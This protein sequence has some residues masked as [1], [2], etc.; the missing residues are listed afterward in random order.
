MVQLQ[1]VVCCSQQFNKKFTKIL[2][3]N[4]LT[5]FLTRLKRVYINLLNLNKKEY[6][7]QYFYLKAQLNLQC[8]LIPERS[9]TS[10]T[11]GMKYT[12]QIMITKRYAIRTHTHGEVLPG[13]LGTYTWPWSSEHPFHH[14][15]E[16]SSVG[17]SVCVLHV[18][19]GGWLAWT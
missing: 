14:E 3:K 2:L 15:H 11:P 1:R 13:C 17:V 6:Y 16:H 5:I 9:S 18:S 10:L 8:Y 19:V 7:F 4:W 12:G